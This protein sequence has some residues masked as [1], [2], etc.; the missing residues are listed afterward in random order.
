MT[1]NREKRSQAYV[2]DNSLSLLASKVYLVPP[3]DDIKK[4]SLF[5]SK[6]VEET[7]YFSKLRQDIG[8]QYGISHA[9]TFMFI[10]SV[11]LC[12][13]ILYMLKNLFFSMRSQRKVKTQPP[14]TEN[15]RR[16]KAISGSQPSK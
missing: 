14:K 11:M 16:K 9:R 10:S 1:K 7:K 8:P 5:R 12:V 4:L 15:K 3:S 2:N 6:K 13:I